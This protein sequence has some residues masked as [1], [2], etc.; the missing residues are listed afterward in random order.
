[1]FR[2]LGALFKPKQ[3][4]YWAPKANRRPDPG[5]VVW[6]WVAFDGERRKG[7]D[8][9]VLLIGT[10][11][12]KYLGL[13]LSSQDHQADAHDEARW[14]RHWITIGPGPWDRQGRHSSVRIDRL[15]VVKASAVRR[16]GGPLDKP[17]F[18]TVVAAARAR[19]TL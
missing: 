2:F 1:M 15:L 19:G 3:R 11:G 16:E 7:K 18:D 14:G 12:R 4:I 8:R 17:R 10:L 9:P 6:T 5:E 13:Q